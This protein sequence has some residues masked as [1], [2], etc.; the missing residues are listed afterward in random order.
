MEDPAAKLLKA[1]AAQSL[2]RIWQDHERTRGPART[3]LA[4]V[5]D[6]LFH[7]DLGLDQLEKLFG[8]TKRQLNKLFHSAVG[9]PP[10]RYIENGRVETA[11]ELLVMTQLK[12]FEIADLLG[13]ASPDVFSEAF[14]RR[15]GIK[16][17]VYRQQ[18]RTRAEREPPSAD[19]QERRRRTESELPTNPRKMDTARNAAAHRGDRNSMPPMRSESRYVPR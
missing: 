6:N 5:G 17:S 11:C 19:R 12:V 4:H 10:Y 14:A 7:P 1:A 2:E 3:V 18:Q 16:P 8:L 9:S 15:L 13:Y